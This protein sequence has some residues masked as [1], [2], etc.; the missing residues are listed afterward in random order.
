[1]FET[2]VGNAIKKAKRL[3]EVIENVTADTY[4]R[5]G[6]GT[7]LWETLTILSICNRDLLYPVCYLKCIMTSYCCSPLPYWSSFR[8]GLPSAVRV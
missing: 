2:H 3:K 1:M 6:V 4:L 7:E 5:A 8:A